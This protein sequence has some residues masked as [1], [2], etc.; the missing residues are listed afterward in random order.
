M[1]LV[2][3]QLR[4]PLAVKRRRMSSVEPFELDVAPGWDQASVKTAVVHGLG[5]L[6]IKNATYTRGGNSVTDTSLQIK[7]NFKQV[8]KLTCLSILSNAR[9][10]EI[11]A[12]K[13]SLLKYMTTMRGVAPDPEGDLPTSDFPLFECKYADENC[14]FRELHLKFLS[15]KPAL[16]AD[17]LL[18]LQLS[19]VNMSCEYSKGTADTAPPLQQGPS[20]GGMGMGLGGAGGVDMMAMMAMSMMGGMPGAMGGKGGMQGMPNE[21]RSHPVRSAPLAAPVA[22]EN[23]MKRCDNGSE[24][25]KVGI[26]GDAAATNLQ[27]P[28]GNSTSVNDTHTP[29]TAVAA[30]ATTTVTATATATKANN[31]PISPNPAILA[32]AIPQSR[33]AA[34]PPGLDIAQLASML[35]TVKG[36]MLEEMGQLLDRKLAPV[37]SRLDQIDSK[38]RNLEIEVCALRRKDCE[39]GA[40]H[41]EGESV[42]VVSS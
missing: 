37:M 11:Y 39:D 33:P 2:S 4:E 6:S 23:S 15:I 36:S 29:T 31:A 26:P 13:D 32:S 41:V 30:T 25:N 5:S 12:L 17:P 19:L 27:S 3:S 40:E 9:F 14:E 22:V 38:L 18:P 10:V 20:M 35:W 7:I 28:S 16:V 1:T 8:N 21:G 34:A 42:L 24:G